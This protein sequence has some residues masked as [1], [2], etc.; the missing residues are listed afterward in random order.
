MTFLAWLASSESHR[1]SWLEKLS[2]TGVDVS[3]PHALSALLQLHHTGHLCKFLTLP[4]LCHPFLQFLH[5]YTLFLNLAT[6]PL[7]PCAPFCILLE[8]CRTSFIPLCTLL[9][10][11]CVSL[12]HTYPSW[13]FI[14]ASLTCLCILASLPRACAFFRLCAV[15]HTF[16]SL[17]MHLPPPR[18]FPCFPYALTHPPEALLCLPHM[19]PYLSLPHLLSR[20]FLHGDAA[21]A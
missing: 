6:P 19:L 18:A 3:H 15:P 7:H 8:L 2:I 10:P 17:A 11:H 13:S 1:G 14:H 9:K 21:G 4:K 20:S 5:S 12:T 16:P